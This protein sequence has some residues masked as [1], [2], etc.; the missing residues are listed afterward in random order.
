MNSGLVDLACRAI[1]V[2]G[3][4]L[5]LFFLGYLCHA[6]RKALA[7]LIDRPHPAANSSRQAVALIGIVADAAL[8]VD[9]LGRV[10]LANP[11]AER[12]FDRAAHAAGHRT[13]DQLLPCPALA[14]TLAAICRR[15]HAD[16][17]VR[18]RAGWTARRP[19]VVSR[20]GPGLA[21]SGGRDGSNGR[22][23]HAQHQQTKNRRSAATP[24]WC[25][26]SATR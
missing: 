14:E 10:T 11:A 16:R 5:A 9:G 1:L 8:A 18:S 21:R 17:I 6:W 2:V 22:P 7:V 20:H 23:G 13:V 19:Q 15:A 25:R 3:G 26:A 12:L 24:I 4:G